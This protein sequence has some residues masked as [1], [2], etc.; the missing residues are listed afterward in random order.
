[1]VMLCLQAQ[2]KMSMASYS[3]GKPI[4]KAGGEVTLVNHPFLSMNPDSSCTHV[5][6]SKGSLSRQKVNKR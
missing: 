3:L 6:A 5:T 2:C 4:A 1:M